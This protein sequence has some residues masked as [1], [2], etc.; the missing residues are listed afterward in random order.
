MYIAASTTSILLSTVRLAH[1]G[2]LKYSLT[3]PAFPSE[4]DVAELESI[5]LFFN[6]LNE[7]NRSGE[8]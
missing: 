1:A 6:P 7:E 4:K 8:R 5:G 2:R 3:S